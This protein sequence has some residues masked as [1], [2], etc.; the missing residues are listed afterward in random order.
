M[1]YETDLT[2]RLA[3]AYAKASPPVAL[4]TDTF[5]MHEAQV[6]SDNFIVL[7]ME[8]LFYW[9]LSITCMTKC[10]AKTCHDILSFRRKVLYTECFL[11]TQRICVSYHVHN[12]MFTYMTVSHKSI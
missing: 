1:T 6:I 11:A 5:D 4:H 12:S 8:E 7:N 9:L 10:V 2:T 3:F